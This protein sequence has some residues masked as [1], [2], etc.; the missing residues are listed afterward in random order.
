MAVAAPV[1]GQVFE[2]PR[3]CESRADT[4]MRLAERH[5][6]DDRGIH[7]PVGSPGIAA[8][9]RQRKAIAPDAQDDARIGR[10]LPRQA[11]VDLPSHIAARPVA[12]G[13]VRLI[14]AL[15]GTRLGHGNGI[16][17]RHRRIPKS[18]PGREHPKALSCKGGGGE[19]RRRAAD[20]KCSP[21]HSPPIRIKHRACELCGPGA[22]RGNVH[23]TS[24][25]TSPIFLPSSK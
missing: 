14:V 13:G 7:A 15:L 4:V 25:K 19:Q 10:Q 5:G 9:A 11:E 8:A 17:S 3:P 2:N 16:A 18:S 20:G 6:G 21:A 22:R 24:R 1:S 12:D 23:A